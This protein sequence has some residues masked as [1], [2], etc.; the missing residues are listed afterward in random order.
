[1]TYSRVVALYDIHGNLP[2]LE[3]VMPE[4]RKAD[5]DCIV[6]GGD[7]TP[8]PM[9]K[10]VLDYLLDQ[11]IPMNFIRGNCDVAILQQ[12]NGEIPNIQKQVLPLIQWVAEDLD[13]EHQRL[14]RTWPLSV[15]LD[16]AGLGKVLFCHATPRDEDEIFCSLTPDDRI[17][18]AFEGV[19]VDVVVCGHTHFQ[20]DRK[21][22]DL[23]IVNSGSVGMP[24]GE[25]GIHWLV[26]G[27]DIKFRNT[28]YDLE[29]A[30]QRVRAT[31]YPAAEAFAT[32]YIL[33]IPDEKETLAVYEK[34]QM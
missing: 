34:F 13:A 21:L 6:I 19:E 14:M 23:R 31:K 16:I 12:L 3:T 9:C 4:V 17:R 30:A 27:P 2:A 32:K 25:N 11:N 26:M 7:V 29:K 8:G 15:T 10:E 1:M 24:F 33:S 5:P 22:G 18:P 28:P 20:D